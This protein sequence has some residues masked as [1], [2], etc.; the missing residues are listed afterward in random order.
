MTIYVGI[1]AGAMLQKLFQGGFTVMAEKSFE[2]L[3]EEEK[4]VKISNGDVVEGT[5]L[6]VKKMR[7]S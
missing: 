3:L 6:A 2:Q 7:L 4:V 1:T 5:V